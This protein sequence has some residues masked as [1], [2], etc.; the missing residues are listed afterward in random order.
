[1]APAHSFKSSDHL[2]D[3]A[4]RGPARGGSAAAHR[5]GVRQA[6]RRSRAD[7]FLRRD[8]RVIRIPFALTLGCRRP[9]ALRRPAATWRPRP[10]HAPVPRFNVLQEGSAVLEARLPRRR[11]LPRRARAC[12]QPRPGH[13]TQRPCNRR[14]TCLL[15]YQERTGFLLTAWRLGRYYRTYPAYVEDE[16]RAALDDPAQLE[17]GPRVYT[18]RGTVDNDAPAFV[19][20]DGNYVS[21]RWPGDAYLLGVRHPARRGVTPRPGGKGGIR[22]P[23][24]T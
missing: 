19:V 23:G 2:R 24:G 12:A 5:R 22:T 15:K 17:H 6:R 9:G 20:E 8:V 7:R 18:R 4:R 16:V 14:T 1:M 11:H 3:R 13:G 10:W 21:A